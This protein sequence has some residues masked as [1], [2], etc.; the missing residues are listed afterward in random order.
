[1]AST[2]SAGGD[3]RRDP[4]VFVAFVEVVP[5]EGCVLKPGEVVRGLARCYVYSTSAEAATAAI[6]DTLRAQK[7]RVV[8][9]EWCVAYTEVEWE[10]PDSPEA[11]ECMA[12]ARD[13]GEV[14]IGRIDAWAGDAN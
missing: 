3:R 9:F 13:S 7:F 2:G 8:G 5:E 4:D 1:M 14:V 11:N 12:E 10:N 6:V